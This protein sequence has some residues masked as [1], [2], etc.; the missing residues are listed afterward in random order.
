MKGFVALALLAVVAGSGSEL[1]LRD[2]IY[3][4]V[5]VSAAALSLG[6]LTQA[7][8]IT[9]LRPF[10]LQQRFR[11]IALR[12]PHAAPLYVPAYKLGYSINVGVTAWRAYMAGRRGSPA[13]RVRAQATA[14]LTGVSVPAAQHID[15]RALR[16]YL[17]KVAV[18]VNRLERTRARGQELDVALA[19]RRI[20]S[21]LLQAGA[22]S[23][24]LPF[25]AVTRHPT[26]GPRGGHAHFHT[27]IRAKQRA[28]V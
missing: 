13:E 7:E 5:E 28:T 15:E 9:R 23:I 4:R 6:G 12:A 8:A 27:A 26:A 21:L 17:F 14:L 19:Q 20:S 22:F 24:N 1:L 2:R 18:T 25:T 11:V 10:S 16:A 3:P